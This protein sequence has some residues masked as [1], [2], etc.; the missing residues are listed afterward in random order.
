MA[1]SYYEKGDLTINQEG[2]LEM[3]AHIEGFSIFKGQ[4]K[5]IVSI[6]PVLTMSTLYAKSDLEID[7]DTE[8]FTGN[9]INDNIFL[10]YK[11]IVGKLGWMEVKAAQISRS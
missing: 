10:R 5:V 11:L 1:I 2:Y 9:A 3:F 6:P 7:R 8:S 4:K